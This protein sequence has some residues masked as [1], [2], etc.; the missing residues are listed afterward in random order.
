MK[1]AYLILFID[2]TTGKSTRALT[3][4]AFPVAQTN[5]AEV[6]ACLKRATASDFQKAHD[7]IAFWVRRNRWVLRYMTREQLRDLA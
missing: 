3:A 1:H 4:S 7:K 5:T 2:T 6:Q